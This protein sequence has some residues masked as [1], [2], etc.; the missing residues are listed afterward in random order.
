MDNDDFPDDTGQKQ[1][2]GNAQGSVV[3]Q[4]KPGQSGNYKGRTRGARSKLGEQFLDALQQ[5]FDKHGVE[6]IEKVREDKPEIYL[7]VIASILPKELNVSAN[8]LDH[9][10]DEELIERIRVL[11]EELRPILDASFGQPDKKSATH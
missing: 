8:E 4:F 3:T 10:S 1:G 6:A 11:N 5:D 7:K 9:L 2:S